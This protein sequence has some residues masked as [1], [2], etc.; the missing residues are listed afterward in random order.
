MRAVSSSSSSLSF[1]YHFKLKKKKKKKITSFLVVSMAKRKAPSQVLSSLPRWWNVVVVVV[2]MKSTS[3]VVSDLFLLLLNKGPEP[4]PPRITSNV[5]QNLQFLKM[6]KACSANS[7]YLVY[8]SSVFSNSRFLPFFQ[9]Y[10][11]R[12]S[13]NPKPATSY[14]RKRQEKE[15]L[16]EDVDLY[17]DPTLSLY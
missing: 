11:K 17:R 1:P 15:E 6:W 16:P 10:Q 3:F 13:S 14:R 2:L 12:T 8:S 9:E 5:K 4:T 7:W